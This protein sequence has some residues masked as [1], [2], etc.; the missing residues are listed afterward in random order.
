MHLTFFAWWC[1]C[2]VWGVDWV[3]ERSSGL[4]VLN[5]VRRPA[6]WSTLASKPMAGSWEETGLMFDSPGEFVPA[7]SRRVRGM[8]ILEALKAKVGYQWSF[9]LQSDRIQILTRDAA[10]Q[11]WRAWWESEQKKQPGR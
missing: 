2:A 5:G 6:I 7:K 1:Y 9:V 4:H 11:F 8:M 10:V 3:L